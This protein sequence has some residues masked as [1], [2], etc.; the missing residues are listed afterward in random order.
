M[1]YKLNPLAPFSP[2]AKGSRE[3]G[4]GDELMIHYKTNKQGNALSLWN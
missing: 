4:L 1:A 3:G 2:L